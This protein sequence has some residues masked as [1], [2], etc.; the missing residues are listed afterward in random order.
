[1]AA[2]VCPVASAHT[3]RG[4]RHKSKRERE[5]SSS[6]SARRSNSGGG[7]GV[8]VEAVCRSGLFGKLLEVERENPTS[9]RSAGGPSFQ[10]SLSRVSTK[11]WVA[12]G[13]GGEALSA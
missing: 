10:S 13:E 1:M 8:D 3:R 12:T 9:F 11:E 5:M 4:S 2:C 6:F 7:G